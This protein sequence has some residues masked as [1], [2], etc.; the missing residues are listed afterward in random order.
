[1]KWLFSLLML[2]V[3]VGCRSPR[4]EAVAIGLDPTFYPLRLMGQE[5]NVE[6]LTRDVMLEMSTRVGR[7]FE[8]VTVSWDNADLAL[9]QGECDAIFSSRYP[10]IFNTSRYDFSSLYLGTG[11]V[12]VTTTSHG[13]NFADREV[14]V[15]RWGDA[16]LALELSPKVIVREYDSIPTVLQRIDQGRLDGALVDMLIASGYVADIYK[17]RLRIASQPLTDEGIRLIALKGEQRELL[18]LFD[19]E[20]DAMRADGSLEHLHTK[21]RL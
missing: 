12:L 9:K 4:H 5:V 10:Y 11:P 2:L 7:P 17:G 6:G 15:R 16:P 18:D 20:L 8:I 21:W 14:A 13:D 19:R 1:M 3:S